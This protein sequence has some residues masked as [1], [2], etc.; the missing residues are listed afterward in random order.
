MGTGPMLPQPRE[1]HTEGKRWGRHKQRME[2]QALGNNQCRELMEKR[3]R[4]HGCK[5]FWHDF[6]FFLFDLSS[7][8]RKL[9][10]MLRI[11]YQE[12]PLLLNNSHELCFYELSDGCVETQVMTIKFTVSMLQNI[13]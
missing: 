11:K 8:Q 1:E 3:P 13:T 4:E 5:F 10:P 2:Q 12:L 6:F 9:A 7:L